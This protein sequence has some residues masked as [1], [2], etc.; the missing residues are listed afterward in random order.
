M[1]CF[2]IIKNGVPQIKVRFELLCVASVFIFLVASFF[3][4][5][6]VKDIMDNVMKYVHRLF[7]KRATPSAIAVTPVGQ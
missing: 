7:D 5:V 6:L 4:A 2:I 3:V 1:Q